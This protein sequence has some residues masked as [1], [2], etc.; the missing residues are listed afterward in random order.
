MAK[1][2]TVAPSA[3]TT[4]GRRRERRR[5]TRDRLVIWAMVLIPTVLVVW[6]VWL[7]ALASIYLSFTKWNGFKLSGIQWIGTK[8][9]VDIATIY[10]AFWPAIRHNLIWL[11]F[12]FVLPTLLGMLLAVILDREMWGSRFYQTAFYLPVVLS[13]ALVGFIWQLFYSTDQG[14]INQVFG[15]QR[16]LVRRPRR[17]PLGRAR[18][19]RVEAH[20]LH[21]ADLPGRAEGRR[22]DAA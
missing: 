13:L 12:L 17:Q 21:H 2:T 6:L 16:R 19:D 1:A 14:L 3:P 8:N 11:V 4:S 18:G 22:L 5:G 7:P 20:R 10:P 15:I 9:Y